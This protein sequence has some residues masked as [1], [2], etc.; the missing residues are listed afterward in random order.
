[1]SRIEE[2]CQLRIF[3]RGVSFCLLSDS[4]SIILLILKCLSTI[5]DGTNTSLCQVPSRVKS[6]ITGENQSVLTPGSSGLKRATLIARTSQR[7]SCVFAVRLSSI[8][9]R[10]KQYLQ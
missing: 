3:T 10:K 6:E 7:K 1:M 9:S 4:V 2:V 8:P 5:V